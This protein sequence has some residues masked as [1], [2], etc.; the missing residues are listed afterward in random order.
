MIH[1]DFEQNKLKTLAFLKSLEKEEKKV[2]LETIRRELKNLEFW[3]MENT[4]FKGLAANT[5]FYKYSLMTYAIHRF[6]S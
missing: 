3:M 2:A 1:T 6:N 5:D 4:V